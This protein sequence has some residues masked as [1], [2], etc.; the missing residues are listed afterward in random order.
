MFGGAVCT[1][2]GECKNKD[3]D[4]IYEELMGFPPGVLAKMYRRKARG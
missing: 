1:C 4:K 3:R 2:Q